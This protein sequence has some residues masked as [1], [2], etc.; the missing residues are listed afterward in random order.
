MKLQNLSFVQLPTIIS[1]AKIPSK[2]SAGNIV[3]L[4]PLKNTTFCIA[5]VFLNE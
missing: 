2:E 3:Y 4:V 5:G 1:T